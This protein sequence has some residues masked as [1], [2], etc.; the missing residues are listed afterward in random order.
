MK[1]KRIYI[2]PSMSVVVIEARYQLLTASDP[3]LQKGRFI[4]TEDPD[5]EWDEEGG[6]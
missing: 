3:T 4:E 5:Y 2:Q 6:N 1:K